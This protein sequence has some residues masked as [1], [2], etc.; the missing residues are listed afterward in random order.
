MLR[1]MKSNMLASRAL[2]VDLD[3]ISSAYIRAHS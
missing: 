3:S 2:L 1:W